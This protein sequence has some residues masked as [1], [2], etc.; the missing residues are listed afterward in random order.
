M[1]T[2]IGMEEKRIR[3]FALGELSKLLG[4]IL[5]R[6]YIFIHTFLGYQDDGAMIKYIFGLSISECEKYLKV[7]ITIIVVYI[8]SFSVIIFK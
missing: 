1:E 6:S 4:T 2:I 3:E 7:I 8:I 5:K